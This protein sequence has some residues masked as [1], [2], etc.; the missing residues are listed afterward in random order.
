MVSLQKREYSKN[1]HVVQGNSEQKLK[2]AGERNRAVPG[3]K[4]VI[5]QESGIG[6]LGP[7]GGWCV[8]ACVKVFCLLLTLLCV[9]RKS[10]S[11]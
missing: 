10:R 9:R 7:G 3:L 4:K 2:T 11:T 8:G 6:D 1:I 5:L